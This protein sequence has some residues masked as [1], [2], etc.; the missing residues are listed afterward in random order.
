M[1]FPK[2][3]HKYLSVFDNNDDYEEQTS[4]IH[5][6]NWSAIRD[7]NQ[8]K[9]DE[10]DYY[11][12]VRHTNE[13]NKYVMKWYSSD[14]LKKKFALE[15]T[16]GYYGFEWVDYEYNGEILKGGNLY[17][18]KEIT[19]VPT[20]ADGYRLQHINNFLNTQ[21]KVTEIEWFDTSNIISAKNAFIGKTNG[22]KINIYNWN[23]LEDATSMFDG[24]KL[25]YPEN[26]NIINMPLLKIAD[27]LFSS[28]KNTANKPYLAQN[29]KYNFGENV[30][31][32]NGTFAY[33]IINVKNNTYIDLLKERFINPNFKNCISFNKLFNNNEIISSFDE[34]TSITLDFNLYDGEYDENK[35]IDLSYC[36]TNLKVSGKII[37][38]LNI[39]H[40]NNISIN[41][42]FSSSSFFNNSVY[43]RKVY[44]SNINK[45]KS[46]KGAFNSC[47]LYHYLPID[48]IIPNCDMEDLYS[49][50]TI[51]FNGEFD[52]SPNGEITSPEHKYNIFS[53]AKIPENF[54]FKN[55]NKLYN[56]SLKNIKFDNPIIFNYDLS[57]EVD[58]IET[59]GITFSHSNILGL[60]DQSIDINYDYSTASDISKNNIN[61]S[62]SIFDHCANIDF[63][64]ANFIINFNIRVFESIPCYLFAGCSSMITTPILKGTIESQGWETL[65]NSCPN[66]K[67][68]RGE[69]LDFNTRI[70]GYYFK[71]NNCPE[72][73][74]FK[75]KSI[76]IEG[77]GI[78]FTNCTKLN[79]SSLYSTLMAEN[80]NIGAIIIMKNVFDQYTE[81]EKASLIN[82][83]NT[84]NIIENESE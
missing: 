45:I 18:I 75:F 9:E 2:Y 76:R 35:L 17:T 71:L 5:E 55:I 66:L 6:C 15:I 14:E 19:K 24:T 51:K 67:Y 23:K 3:E 63:T 59:R 37:P 11:P 52:F 69:E 80:S 29:V 70:Y 83:I 12:S 60:K 44:F 47:T 40:N 42:L 7:P 53:N 21:R 33:H 36:F 20:I 73:I 68:I 65:F 8:T 84:I 78:D 10:N 26:I 38:T 57:D 49:N 82:K 62:L 30:L 43:N 16:W 34:Y 54:I 74:D 50:T 41:Y 4:V 61:D 13:D 79:I 31:S 58:Y 46:C 81:E 27:N 48:R 1:E 39:I 22:L 25:E 77:H 64:D 72:L 28:T 56:I 32:L